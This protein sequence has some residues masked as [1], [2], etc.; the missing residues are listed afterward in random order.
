MAN[1]VRQQQ[2]LRPAKSKR[3][4][5]KPSEPNR[6]EELNGEL[7]T[8]KFHNQ[9]EKDSVGEGKTFEEVLTERDTKSDENVAT[10]DTSEINKDELPE[11]N[12]KDAGDEAGCGTV[13]EDPSGEK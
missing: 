6:L 11:V 3:T 7:N 2:K 8:L 4:Q 12:D 9:E 5:K 10:L 1:A 13:Q